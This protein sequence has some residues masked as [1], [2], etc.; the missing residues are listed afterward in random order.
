MEFSFTTIPHKGGLS[1]RRKD[2]GKEN[3]EYKMRRMRGVVWKNVQIS[4]MERALSVSSLL[5]Y[6]EEKREEED[7]RN[8]KGEKS[9]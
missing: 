7:E 2:G 1:S 4:L 6:E 9:K 5:L 3:G 8:T